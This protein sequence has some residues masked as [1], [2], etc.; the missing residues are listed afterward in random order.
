M[1]R[2]RQI[3]RQ[4]RRLAGDQGPQARDGGQS[5]GLKGWGGRAVLAAGLALPHLPPRVTQ[6]QLPSLLRR[7]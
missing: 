2:S 1:E 3:D 4:E 6:E 5:R 7:I